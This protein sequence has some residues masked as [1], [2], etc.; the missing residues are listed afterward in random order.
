MTCTRCGSHA[1]NPNSHG[2]Q[3]GIDLDLCDVCYWRKR[4][5]TAR[6]D[7]SAEIDAIEAQ[8]LNV[9]LASAA[10]ERE[11]RRFKLAKAAITGASCRGMTFQEMEEIVQNAREL[12]DATL[13]E[14]ERTK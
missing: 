10:Q 4:A 3:P 14:L 6:R 2:R 1:I 5:E 7:D 13:A 12:A 11:Y 8:V 9:E